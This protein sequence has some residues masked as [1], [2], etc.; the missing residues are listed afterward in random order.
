M[1]VKLNNVFLQKGLPRISF[2]GNQTIKPD[3][4]FKFFTIFLSIVYNNSLI[5]ATY[6]AE[7]IKNG[8]QH[9]KNLQT[10]TDFFE[11]VFFSCVIFLSG[12]QLRVTGKLGGKL[13][14]SKYHYKLGK[15]KLQTFKH[16][17]SYSLVPSFTKFGVISI[18]V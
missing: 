6:L 10:F 7:M 3:F 5:L 15:V 9:R 4:R 8:K 12:F 14:K 2:F 1:N 11:R 16:F 13:R 18:K 17:L